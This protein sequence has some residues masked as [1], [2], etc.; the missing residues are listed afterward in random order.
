VAY[1]P[2]ASAGRFLFRLYGYVLYDSERD[3]EQETVMGRMKL[4]RINI[5]WD[6]SEGKQLLLVA[7]VFAA[8]VGVSFLLGGDALMG[9]LWAV[10]VATIAG[11][12]GFAPVVCTGANNT[13]LQANT[14]LLAGI[15]RMLLMLGGTA[16]V[17]YFVKID[18]LWFIEWLVLFYVV[19][20]V[21]EIRF[22]V[23]KINEKAERF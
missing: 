13:F 5:D 22:A 18:V 10:V 7:A 20:L 8:S 14:I 2:V 11:A 4:K 9:C 21:M 3:V 23:R 1:K 17:L 19:M 6:L 16:V 12:I 15:I